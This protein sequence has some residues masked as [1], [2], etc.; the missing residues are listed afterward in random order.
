M[1]T[2]THT[3]RATAG[4]V[5]AAVSA[6]MQ[7]R[8]ATG[9]AREQQRAIRWG[10]APS[11]LVLA[12]V[13][14]VPAVWL[15]VVS[16]TPLSPAAPGSYDFSEPWQNYQQAFTTPE[17]VQ[18]VLVQVELSAITVV[19][20]VAAGLGVALLLDKPS[21]LLRSVRIATNAARAANAA[22]EANIRNA[23]GRK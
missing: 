23:D 21:S 4:S 1:A 2:D 19:F 12:L 9:W 15:L 20:Q 5:A 13:T 11:V 8:P 17:F 14:V 16:L 3:E 18:S 6:P 22:N 10:L 7:R